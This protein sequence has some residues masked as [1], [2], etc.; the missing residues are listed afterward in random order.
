MSSSRLA[1]LAAQLTDVR[2]SVGRRVLTRRLSRLWV[3]WIRVGGRGP[4]GTRFESLVTGRK[5]VVAASD[6]DFTREWLDAIEGQLIQYSAFWTKWMGTYVVGLIVATLVSVTISTRGFARMLVP[7]GT[8]LTDTFDQFWA[9]LQAI[10]LGWFAVAML[11]LLAWIIWHVAVVLQMMKQ[12]AY[13]MSDRLTV[14]LKSKTIGPDA[15]IRLQEIP[16]DALLRVYWKG[17]IPSQPPTT[18]A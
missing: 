16:H 14:A 10:R 6:A 15:A 3:A 4:L 2:R 9:L 5:P 12:P 1:S 18:A 11:A 7:L 8:L 13:T 17:L